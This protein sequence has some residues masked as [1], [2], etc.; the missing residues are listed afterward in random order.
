MRIVFMGSPDFAVPS[1]QQLHQNGY[2]IVGVV[3]GT[4]KKRGRGSELSPTPVKKAALELSLNVLEVDDLKS[5]DFSQQL[6]TLRPDLFI[7]VAFRVL[8]KSLLE[9]PTIGSINLHASLLPKYRG[10]AP[11]HRAVMNGDR[12][13]GVTIFF[14][15]ERVDTGKYLVQRNV[16][17]GPNETTGDIY[18]KLMHTGAELLV[19]AAETI[20]NGDYALIPQDDSKASPAPKLFSND[21]IVDF[22]K[23]ADVV[24]NQIRGLSPFPTA[25]TMLDDKRFKILRTMAHPEV[26][27]PVG[28]LH[29]VDGVPYIGCNSGAV[30]LVEVQI[31]GK[32]ATD[33]ASFARGY[34]GKG[35]ISDPKK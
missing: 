8:S 4:D 7:V 29:F 14:L 30:E 10:A 16:S 5:P 34:Q 13:T 22:D 19:A 33:G 24:H 35:I 12:E 11:I 20:K 25:F 26:K 15:D 3:T 32:R 21:C 6:A 23:N 17:I 27:I 28:K 2:E 1:L 31:E 9:I 18:S